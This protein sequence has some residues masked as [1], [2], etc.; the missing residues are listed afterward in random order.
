M[1]ATTRG[2][3]ESADHHDRCRTG[4]AMRM[5]SGAWG[6]PAWRCSVGQVQ[7]FP[8]RVKAVGDVSLEVQ[9][10]WNPNEVLPPAA[11]VPL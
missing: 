2:G 7:G 9:V 11:M 3:G 8:L 10:P 5:P 1:P 4:S 6:A